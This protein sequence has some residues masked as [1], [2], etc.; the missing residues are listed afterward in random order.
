MTLVVT[1]AALPSFLTPAT[2]S[3]QDISPGDGSANGSMPEL[4]QLVDPVTGNIW[5]ELGPIVLLPNGNV[6]VIGGGTSNTALY[7][8]TTNTWSSGPEIPYPYTSDNT[9]AAVLPNGDVIFTAD[10][11]PENG[12]YTGPTAFFDYTP[13]ANGIGAGTITQLTGLNAP[14]DPGLA[15]GS[16]NDRMLMLPTGQLMFSDSV[17]GETWVGTP[18]GAPLPQW[19]PVVSSITGSGSVYTLTGQRLNGM[20]AGAAYGDDAEMDENYPIVRLTNGLEAC[21][22]PRLQTGTIWA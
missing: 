15:Y 22:M 2:G 17:S 16:Y 20:D 4:S 5:G 9:P 6:F 21:I 8:P 11:A 10:A 3:W 1:S 18:S 7:S 14:A 12:Q 19:R 13:P